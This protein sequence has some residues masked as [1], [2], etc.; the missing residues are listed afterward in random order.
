MGKLNL[1]DVVQALAD[2]GIPTERAFPARKLAMITEPVAAVSL[3]QAQM[4]GQTLTV[5]VRIL[6]PAELGA[7]TCEETALAAGETL[8]EL[9]G[10]CTVEECRFDGRTGMFSVDITAQFLTEI[11]KVK[12]NGTLLQYVEAF[13]CWRTVDEDAG[14]TELDQAKWYFR[15]EE[16]FP[17]GVDEEEEPEEPFELMHISAIGSETYCS[18]KW[19]YQRRVWGSTGIRQIRLGAA[20]SMDNG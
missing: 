7:A 6:S 10:D 19:T 3:K 17:A 11:P 20:E 1:G 14:V 13:T 18:C 9:G 8:T 5:Q 2:A 4:R 16:F 15:L 12:L